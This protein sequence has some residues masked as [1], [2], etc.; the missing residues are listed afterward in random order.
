MNINPTK[1][2]PTEFMKDLSRSFP[3]GASVVRPVS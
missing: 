3:D 1:L 2:M